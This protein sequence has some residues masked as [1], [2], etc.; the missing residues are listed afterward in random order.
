MTRDEVVEE[1]RKYLFVPFRHRG[2]LPAYGLD[3]LGL[4]I[5]VAD[6]FGVHYEDM[7]DYSNQPHPRRLVLTHLRKFL[8]P[9]PITGNLIGCVGIFA[10][11]RLPAHIGFFSW[12]ENRQHVVHV[13]MDCGVAE[14]PFSHDVVK[15]PMRIIDVLAFPELED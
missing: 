3:C 11:V 13:R 14:E 12:K 4:G 5:V 1:A 8:K 9:M 7:P 10:M 15:S 6:H 2:R